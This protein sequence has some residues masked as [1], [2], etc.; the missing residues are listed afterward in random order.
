MTKRS[1]GSRSRRPV[2]YSGRRVACLFTRTLADGSTVFEFSGRLGGE[3]RRH[4]LRAGT[5]TDAIAELRAL[6][7]DYARGEARR[8]PAAGATVEDLAR[9]W[10][11]DLDARVGSRDP[12]LRRSARTVKLYRSRLDAFV[13]PV[14]GT[15]P[16]AEVD[17]ADVRR[18][19]SKASARL[20]P[21]TASS[22]LSILS[23]LLRFGVKVG[24]LERN[25]ARDLDPR[26][27]PRHASPHRTEVPLAGRGRAPPLEDDRHVPSGRRDLRVRG[28]PCLGSA[29]A[30]LARRRP[31]G[32][33]AGR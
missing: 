29:R 7:T 11:A 32:R 5:P 22:V 30:R 33:D 27:P 28:P 13:V 1:Y 25:P 14:I 16:A 20:A 15:V 17:V 24:A 18:V 8:S 21:G 31:S 12:R 19:V 2:V 23:G 9:E 10:V 26:R 4:V 6:Q 3:R